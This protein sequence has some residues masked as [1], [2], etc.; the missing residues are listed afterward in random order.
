MPK[1]TMY[2]KKGRIITGVAAATVVM[3]FTVAT[4]VSHLAT[5]TIITVSFNSPVEI[6]VG[7]LFSC[8]GLSVQPLSDGT[9]QVT[10]ECSGQDTPPTPTEIE[11]STPPP[12]PDP[13]QPIITPQEYP[14]IA[15]LLLP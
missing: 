5:G 14:V 4:V 7:Q 10:A 15:P 6:E 8:K 13:T 3:L 9:F 2:N 1:R 12:Y 11:Q